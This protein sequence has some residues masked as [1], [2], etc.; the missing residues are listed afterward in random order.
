MASR[1]TVWE[2]SYRGTVR[3]LPLRKCFRERFIRDCSSLRLYATPWDLQVSS[4][5]HI[6]RER[7]HLLEDNESFSAFLQRKLDPLR[8]WQYHIDTSITP[9]VDY[10]V[11]LHGNQIVDFVGRYESLQADFDH[12]CERIGLPVQALP[13][14]RRADDRSAYREYYD[15]ES[16]A[17]VERHFAADIEAFGYKF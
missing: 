9:Q 3:R 5:H 4:Y 12:C 1:D 6:K 10:L 14:R 16:K 7:P 13:H 2:S 17:L 15:D 8:E 11:D